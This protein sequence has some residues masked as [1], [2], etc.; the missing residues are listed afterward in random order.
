M[1]IRC[2]FLAPWRPV[3]EERYIVKAHDAGCRHSAIT[4]A[5]SLV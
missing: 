5:F 3:C 2:R 4:R 1:T